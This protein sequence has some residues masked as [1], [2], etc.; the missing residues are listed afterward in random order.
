[1]RLR[2]AN[3]RNLFSP[4]TRPTGRRFDPL[5]DPHQ[6]FDH[7]IRTH[8]SSNLH[9][10]RYLITSLLPYFAFFSFFIKIP[11]GP[12]SHVAALRVSS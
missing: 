9:F 1:M 5:S 10:R 6:I 3:Q 7:D 8:A 12:L 11:R 4:A 2:D